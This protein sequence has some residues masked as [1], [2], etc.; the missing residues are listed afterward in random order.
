QSV[1]SPEV[2]ELHQKLQKL[3]LELNIERACRETEKKVM[4]EREQTLTLKLEQYER[5]LQQSIIRE[6]ERENEV[7]KKV[8][9]QM[10]RTFTELC[11]E[12]VSLKGVV[13]DLK[14]LAYLLTTLCYN[15]LRTSPNRNIFVFQ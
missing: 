14:R 2:I 15:L 8:K 13:A 5:G 6:M 3:Q 9:A 1:P 11:G 7:L 12:K 10:Q 4:K